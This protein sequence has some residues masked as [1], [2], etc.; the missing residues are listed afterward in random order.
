MSNF[1]KRLVIDLENDGKRLDNI[2]FKIAKKTPKS[3]IYKLIRKGRIK[4]NEKK[5]PSTK[6]KQATLS[7]FL[8][9]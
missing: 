7:I 8:V 9:T 5:Q 6:L 3:L 2:L 1:L 4:V